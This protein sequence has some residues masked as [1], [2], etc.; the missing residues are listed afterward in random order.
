MIAVPSLA[1]ILV[2]IVFI[3]K[4]DTWEADNANR[5][6]DMSTQAGQLFDEK[7][8]ERAIDKYQEL[9]TF[10]QGRQ[11]QDPKLRE[12]TSQ[13]VKKQNQAREILERH[14]RLT[15]IERLLGQAMRL[16]A[17]KQFEKS[18]ES[19]KLLL[20]EANDPDDPE[21]QLYRDKANCGMAL[22]SVLSVK[23]DAD[24]ALKT[25]PPKALDLY[26]KALEAF[27]RAKV[28]SP[29]LDSAAADLRQTI[30][31]VKSDI[32]TAK[33]E[34]AKQIEAQ[35]LKGQSLWPVDN[36]GNLAYVDSTGN[37]ALKTELPFTECISHANG[38][39]FVDGLAIV[40]KGKKCGL[41][42]A[43][44]DLVVEPEYDDIKPSPDTIWAVRSGRKWGYVGRDGKLILA[45]CLAD[46]R[47]F[48]NGLAAV[49]P[50]K[51]WGFLGK[52]G[53]Y[54]IMPQFDD[55]GQFGEALASACMDGN[56]GYI[57]RTGKFVI[58]PTYRKAMP[59]SFGRAKVG[60]DR[61]S[62]FITETGEQL[63]KVIYEDAGN[64]SD[65]M[66]WV[67]VGGK[68]G[69]IGID[70]EMVIPA[71]YDV[72]DD[73]VDG[74]ALVGQTNTPATASA[75]VSVGKKPLMHYMFI[76]KE[77]KTVVDLGER[78]TGAIYKPSNCFKNEMCVAV[79]DVGRDKYVEFYDKT[80]QAKFRAK[81]E[82]AAAGPDVWKIVESAR[83]KIWYLINTEGKVVWKTPRA[84]GTVTIVGQ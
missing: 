59:F 49:K 4:R 5:I 30:E 81:G 47:P 19:F 76:D 77:G 50:D 84:T 72:A 18:N 46:A 13:A 40:V 79:I 55:V 24:S 56:W 21:V 32:D 74:L 70:G 42:T 12:L 60:S 20:A 64:F 82:S 73:F 36:L 11:L 38:A 53:E 23:A 33:V 69:Y 41:L 29:E 26:V 45:I 14:N 17:S 66:A 25:N 6:Q 51:K 34:Q 80:G 62:T 9:Q 54:A 35:R 16:Q 61:Q 68:I 43:D 8:Y 37:I 7:K 48:S 83:D 44:G 1:A 22:N 63:N 75:P 3:A 39:I 67:K 27:D 28:K 65:A 15:D 71:Q 57:D 78:P 58:E 10:V 52:D 31:Q 2:L